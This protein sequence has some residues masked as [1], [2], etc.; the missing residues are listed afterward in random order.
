MDGDGVADPGDTLQYNVTITNTSAG[1]LTGVALNV[2][3][4]SHTTLVGGSIRITPI[5]FDDAYA[6]TGNTP[7][8]ITAGAGLLANDID[9]D[10]TTPLTNIGL[11]AVSLNTAGTLGSVTLNTDGSFTYTPPTNFTG[12]DTFQYTARDADNLNS[13]V[14]GTVTMT[15]SGMVWYVDSSY[16]GG[17]GASDGSFNRPF[18]TLTPLNGAG[19]AGDADLPGQTI[20]VYE[21]GSSY[22]GGIELENNQLLIGESVGLTVNGMSIGGSGGNP[23]IATGTAANDVTLASGNTVRGFTLGNT[24]GAKIAGAN[25]GTATISTVSMTGAGAAFDLNTGNLSANITSLASTSSTTAIR[26]NNVT[27][28]LSSGG[29]AGAGIS[30]AT[31]PAI[32]II[33][34]SV[35]IVHNPGVTQSN[36]AA[37]LSVSG[38]HTGSLTFQSFG[39][40]ASNGTG[41]VFDNADGTYTFNVGTSLSGGAA[42]SIANGSSGTFN[43][44]L[45]ATITNP[46][47]TAFSILNSDANVTYNG[48]ISK[49]SAGFLIDIDNHDAGTVTFQTGTLSST[50]SSSGLRVQNSNGGSVNFNNPTKTLNTAANT[51]VTL[52]TN[53]AGGTMNFGGGGL[54][55]DTT[56]G[57]GFSATGGGTINVTGTNNSITTTSGAA[58]DVANTTIGASD[59]N[60]RSITSTNA[61]ADAISLSS[62]GT[63]GGLK[64]GAE[65]PGTPT[66]GDGGTITNPGDNAISLVNT[67][68]KFFRGLLV[69][70]TGGHGV[71]GTGMTDGSGGAEATLEFRN[72][73]FTSPGDA[74][75][76]T[77][78][79]FG[80]ILSPGNNTGSHRADGYDRGAVRGAGFRRVTIIPA[81]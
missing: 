7:I 76:E 71:F 69:N 14:T 12:T 44:L 80:T 42:V 77:G 52:N 73:R 13:L 67:S 57:T 41:L 29:G 46:S 53:N 37:L 16:G 50:G 62:T 64:V 33:G 58:I 49:S 56:T 30:G 31:G 45:G 9:P 39:V 54:D 10:A 1:S 59:L 81:R 38:G 6:L 5:A 40:T 18:T 60:F 19:G 72:S 78:L 3:E 70:G 28:S 20:F 26:M 34:G 27:G 65:L 36:N 2:N 75:N 55:I 48:S 68:N 66:A 51:A 63:S 47:S 24:T 23:T 43:F 22:T 15:V 4:D 79:Y 61:A 35:S 11:T 8:T 74:D 25:F 32:E 21:S 17:N